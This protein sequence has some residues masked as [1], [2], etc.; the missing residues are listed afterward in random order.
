MN[1]V[2]VPFT[3]GA[4]ETLTTMLGLEANLG[5]DERGEDCPLA[6]YV[7]LQGERTGRLVLSFPSST[8][9]F[10]VAE[11]M[12][13]DLDEMDDEL[14]HDGV[15]EVA[16][17]IAGYAKTQLADTAYHFSLHLP[18]VVFGEDEKRALVESFPVVYHNRIDTEEGYFEVA[19]YFES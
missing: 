6:A 1:E 12:A 14:L 8:A 17:M 11:M 2:L 16:N 10:L 5:S 18:S 19:V 7:D 9:S 13:V 3:Q 15:G 4:I